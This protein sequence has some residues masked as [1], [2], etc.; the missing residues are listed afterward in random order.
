M[1]VLEAVFKIKIKKIFFKS[2]LID[3]MPTISTEGLVQQHKKIKRSPLSNIF[4]L[5]LVV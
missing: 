4:H 1:Q 3:F 5:E 2:K